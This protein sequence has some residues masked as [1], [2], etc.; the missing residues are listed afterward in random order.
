[1]ESQLRVLYLH[2]R[3]KS[4]NGSLSCILNFRIKRI[5]ELNHWRRGWNTVRDFPAISTWSQHA[6]ISGHPT[7]ILE[8]YK[9]KSWKNCVDPQPP[10][11]LHCHRKCHF[12]RKQMTPWRPMN[13]CSMFLLE[14]SE[15]QVV[16]FC[17]NLE[18][19]IFLNICMAISRTNLTN[20]C[21]HLS[22]LF[23]WS[24]LIAYREQDREFSNI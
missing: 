11:K 3:Y 17:H 18:D 13:H 12:F 22:F 2:L 4:L 24:L 19:K 7:V 6:A 20:I 5:S 1:M 8:I 16:R 21:C 9:Q 15:R 23:P 14:Y 10:G